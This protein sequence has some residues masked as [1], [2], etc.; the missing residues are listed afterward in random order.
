M[1]IAPQSG[2]R[3]ICVG[4]F[5]PVP[6]YNYR[7]GV[8]RPGYYRE[9]LNT[10]AALWGG[11]NVGNA[12]GVVAESVLSNGLPYSISIALPPLGVLWFDV[13]RD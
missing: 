1:R 12:G 3:V 8:P 5:S 10:D 6:R 9:I 2:Q 4:N 13:P 11:S 7:V